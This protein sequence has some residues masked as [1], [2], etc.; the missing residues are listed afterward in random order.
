MMKSLCTTLAVFLMGLS[1]TMAQPELDKAEAHVKDQDYIR[2]VEE[3]RHAIRK[4]PTN[5]KV[6]AT[7]TR[8]YLELDIADT[9][10]MYG[11][12]LYEEDNQRDENVWLYSEALM[13]SGNNLE[14]ASLLRKQIKKSNS[15][16]SS[17]LL[18]DALI[19]ADSLGS[20]ELVAT[21]A[22]AKFASS[23]DAYIALGNIYFNYKPQPVFDLAIANYEE[24]V[25]L[26]P[27]LV[28]PHFN[29]AQCYWAQANRESDNELA[30]ELFKRSLIEWDKVTQLD[31]KNARAWF[32]KGKILYL[33]KRYREAAGSLIRYRQLRPVGT[34]NPLASWYLGNSFY[35]VRECDS[36][37]QHL[38]DAAR[39]IDSVRSKASLLMAR[40]QFFAKNWA[41][42]AELFGKVESASATLESQDLWYYGATLVLAGDTAKA[43]SVMDRAATAD[44]KQCTFMFRYG[45][46]LQQQQKNEASTRI[47]KMRLA[48]CSDSLD[49]RIM[50]L[51]GNNFFADSLVDSAR[52]MYER[53]VA[54]DSLTPYFLSRLAEITLIQNDEARAKG[55]FEKVVTLGRNGSASDKQAAIGAIGRLNGMDLTAKRCQQV[56][57][58][59][60][61][62]LEIDPRSEA[63]HLWTAVGYQCL[64]DAA[65]AKKYYREVLRI[66]PSN[67]TAKQNLKSLGD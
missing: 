32:E 37:R 34:G 39:Q 22:K 5:Q 14:A 15:V 38:D 33:G 55:L 49:A 7:A 61:T 31:P 53:A 60:K 67:G 36:A 18:V 8:I 52:A 62:G 1:A 45:V 24:A 28:Q 13:E 41:K 27:N 48:N 51:I 6:L 42:S 16:Q 20:A 35:E 46:L 29:L 40:C 11:K 64:N 12:R 66:N 17:L 21:T 59:S 2:A 63:M 57:D 19:A 3:I 47:L 4:H 23:P 9:A 54:K 65:N 44:P 10:L 26:D 25:K 58:R 30:N 50:V 43:I 56:V